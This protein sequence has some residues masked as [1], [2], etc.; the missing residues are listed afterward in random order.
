[1]NNISM[2]KDL[3]S[4]SHSPSWN[5]SGCYKEELFIFNKISSSVTHY[6]K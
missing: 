1:M 4:L 6:E 2:E 3:V 5:L